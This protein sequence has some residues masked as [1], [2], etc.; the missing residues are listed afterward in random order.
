MSDINPGTPPSPDAQRPDPNSLIKFMIELAPLIVFFAA[1][2]TQG[3]IQMATGAIILATLVSLLASWLL[4]KKVA[5]MPVVTAA[6]VSIFGGLTLW[7][8]DPTFFFRKPTIVNLIF[9]AILGFGLATGRPL[10]KRLF[11]GQLKLTD[12]GWH[13]LT[14][15]WTVFFLAMAGLNEIVWRN[16]A[17]TTWV[18]FKVFGILPMTLLFAIAQVGLMSRHA[19]P[20]ET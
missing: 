9:A 13:K 2:K 8:D 1:Y 12:E 5:I 17:E 18:N 20:D 3:S 19:V 15:R 6:V 10:V 14:V 16:F 7:L 4:F 11:D